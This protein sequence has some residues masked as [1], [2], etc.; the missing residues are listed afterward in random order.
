MV[1][2]PHYISDSHQTYGTRYKN[3]Y[4]SIFIFIFNSVYNRIEDPIS[5]ERFI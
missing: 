4:V 5:R 2:M 3:E 1:N